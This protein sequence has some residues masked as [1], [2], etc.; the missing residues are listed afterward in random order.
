MPEF[1]ISSIDLKYHRPEESWE[2]WIY[3]ETRLSLWLLVP[4]ATS[5]ATWIYTHT[6]FD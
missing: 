1:K 5:H 3:I 4:R 2:G 6:A